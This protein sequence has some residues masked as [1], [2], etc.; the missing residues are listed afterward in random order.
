MIGLLL[1]RWL[2]AGAMPT[3][4]DQIIFCIGAPLT[5]G[6]GLE[7]VAG[8]SWIIIMVATVMSRPRPRF[9]AMARR[10]GACEEDPKAT[11]DP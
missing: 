9:E 11:H 4:T 1:F 8:R 5:V 6:M 3:A 2:F 10:C 7:A